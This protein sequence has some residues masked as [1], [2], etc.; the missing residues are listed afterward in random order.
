[1]AHDDPAVLRVGACG[2]KS[3]AVVIR[4]LE[5]SV[6]A[7]RSML[8]WQAAVNIICSRREPVSGKFLIPI[9]EDQIGHGQ[10]TV[11][12]FHL[13]APDHPF[14]FIQKLPVRFPLHMRFPSRKDAPFTLPEI[15]PADSRLKLCKPGSLL[16]RRG[17]LP[18]HKSAIGNTSFKCDAF[19]MYK[20][21]AVFICTVIVC[22][23]L[24][25]FLFCLIL[26]ASPL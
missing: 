9:P 4:P 24:S 13:N 15:L 10:R 17:D 5:V 14:Q 22:I 18:G 21:P 12:D 1:M 3:T 2:N 11:S 7:C 23:Q 19:H 26:S 8:P 16:N 20:V 6:C 25:Q